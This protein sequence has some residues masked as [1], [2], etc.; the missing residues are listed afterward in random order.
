MVRLK[1]ALLLCLSIP[2]FYFNS[3]MVRL[4]VVN[5]AMSSNSNAFQFQ[6]GAIERLAER[7]TT[8]QLTD[9]NS[10]MVRLKAKDFCQPPAGT[11][12]SIPVWCD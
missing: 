5:S 3:S 6:Y 1:G 10:S 8:Y 11:F 7:F 4:K 2:C 12:I 9:F